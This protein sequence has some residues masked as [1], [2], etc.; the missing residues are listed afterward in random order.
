MK[1]W[2]LLAAGALLVSTA[3][4]AAGGRYTATLAK[5]VEGKKEIIAGQNQWNCE[6]S[7]CVLSSQPD[8]PDSLGSCRALQRRV[9][10]L[11]AYGSPEKAFDAAKL[12]KCNAR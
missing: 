10:E 2:T 12:A 1:H 7:S 3:A 9:G 4:F 8:S 5:P 6:G 11:T